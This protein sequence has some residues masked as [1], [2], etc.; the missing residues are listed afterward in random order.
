MMNG[1]LISIGLALC[2][3]VTLNA[4]QKK[5]NSSKKEPAPHKHYIDIYAAGGVSSLGYSLEG[6]KTSLGIAFSAGLG[7]TWFFRPVIGLQTGVSLT[8]L[9]T[10]ATLVNEMQWAGLTDY[11]GDEY[12]H[13]TAFS[14]WTEKQQAY[15][16]EIPLGLRFRYFANK[17]S[18]AGLHA[19]FGAKLAMPVIANFKHASGAV[20]HYA[21]YD[22]WQLE[23]RDL[24][25]RFE[26]ETIATPQEESVRDKLNVVNAEAYAELGIA[27]RAGERTEISIAA[28]GQ[29]LINDFCAVKRENRTPLGFAN[30][31]N[32]YS[33]MTEYH[34]LIGTNKIGAMH[35]WMAGLKIGVSVWP[36]KTDKQKK[37]EL[38][39]LAKQFPELMPVKE[40]HDTI[41]LHDTIYIRE[42]ADRHKT[43]DSKNIA[44]SGNRK[45]MTAA[46][47]QLDDLLSQAVI[48]FPFDKS[49]P[50]LEPAYILDSVASMMATHPELRIHINGHACK[51][52]TEQYNL[53]LALRRALAITD[54]LRAKGVPEERMFVRTYGAK[55]PYRYNGPHQL[56]KDR[57]VEIIPE[58]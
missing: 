5:D 55:Q 16:V 11:A 52:G 48:W 39:K 36:G 35:P 27:L 51:I 50:I 22:Y 10:K 57:R 31:H 32:N 44:A 20:T 33:F 58:P 28:Y 8:R 53:R 7:Y 6:G 56:S 12:I 9:A 18:K 26:T 17:D 43:P 15:L 4:A 37:K 47:K 25:G 46:Q 54:M 49:D 21:W 29:Y 38:K 41:Y 24:P 3:V 14:D 2:C 40:I 19:A 34:G 42:T 45:P 30:A 1:R 23:L 13:R